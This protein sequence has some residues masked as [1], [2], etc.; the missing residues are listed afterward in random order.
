MGQCD[1]ALRT[2]AARAPSHS[3]RWGFSEKN[4]W[5]DFFSEADQCEQDRQSRI[6]PARE[7]ALHVVARSLEVGSRAARSRIDRNIVQADPS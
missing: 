3:K 5:G 6:L 7:T 4:R 1:L 2:H